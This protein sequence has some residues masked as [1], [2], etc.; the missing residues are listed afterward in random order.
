M[1]SAVRLAV[2]TIFAVL[3]RTQDAGSAEMRLVPLPTREPDA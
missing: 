1:E 2:D 3:V